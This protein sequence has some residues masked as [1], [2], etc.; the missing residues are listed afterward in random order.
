MKKYKKWWITIGIV[1]I[2]CVIGYV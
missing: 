1:L 2:L